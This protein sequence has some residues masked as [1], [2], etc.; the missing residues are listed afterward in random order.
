MST[1]F[2]ASLLIRKLERF[3][4]WR[5]DERHAVIDAL[6]S[7]SRLHAHADFVQEGKKP[8]AV[9]VMLE[10][11]ACGYKILADGRRQIVSY[12]IPGD[13]CDIRTLL[14]PRMDY[15][16]ATLGPAL[17]ANLN[18]ER[19]QDI[20]R[21]YPR[22]LRAFWRVALVEQAIAREW[23]VNVGQR[24]AFARAAHLLCEF[25]VRLRA[26]GLVHD[27]SCEIPLTQTEIADTLALST[28]HVNRTL[29][30]LRRHGLITLRDKLLTIH[31]L[32]ALQA[33]A[34]FD[35]GYLH[36]EVISNGESHPSM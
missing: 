17:V 27:N 1:T 6:A 10:G 35:A 4:P 5:E 3:E 11:F 21:R 18:R 2:L 32:P 19:L 31:D 29:M 36:L 23:L 9:H 7:T 15:S 26:V 8:D 22:L 14:I 25:F 24:T 13:L 12:C 28:V 30:E 16:V 20:T 34:G 33:A